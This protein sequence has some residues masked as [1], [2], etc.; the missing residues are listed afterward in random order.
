MRGAFSTRSYRVIGI[1]GDYWELP[2]RES[3]TLLKNK[4]YSQV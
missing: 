2:E 3:E 4:K 1:I